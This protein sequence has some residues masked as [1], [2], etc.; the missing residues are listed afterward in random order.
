[1][2]EK[3]LM[4]YWNYTEADLNA[5]QR[6]Q[7]TEKQKA[8]LA[9]KQKEQ[10]SYNS[11]LGAIVVGALGFLLV[12][13]LFNP[14]RSAI[15]E[16]SAEGG[17]PMQLAAILSVVGI[18]LAMI[19]GVTIVSLRRMNRKADFAI[20]HA[21]GKVNFVWVESKVRTQTGSGHKTVRSLEMHVGPETKFSGM[22]AALP[23]LI[24]QGDEWII[25]YVTY[26]FM[27][28]SAEKISKGNQN[29]G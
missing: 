10:K 14:V 28:L 20:R 15:Q 23:N 2:T 1:M 21:E 26:P 12:G 11:C 24:D 16:F 19:V 8:V 7:L 4:E 13:A 18:L 3:H 25:Y 5:N 17:Q 27:F 29:H 6:G 9:E 22:D